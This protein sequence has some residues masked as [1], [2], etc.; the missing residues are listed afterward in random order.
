VRVRGLTGG[1]LLTIGFVLLLLAGN[2][3]AFVYWASFQDNKIGRANN[4]GTG[5]NGSF[6]STGAG[7]SA[8]A[9]NGSHIYWVNQTGDTIGRANLD[10]TGADNNFITGVNAPNAVAVSNSFL[11]WSSTSPDR[12]GRANLDGT[13]PNPNLIAG[14]ITPCGVAAD[15]GH[16]Y[17]TEDNGS[18]SHIG[19]SDL[20]G[21]SPSHTFVTI[22]GTSF[23]CGVAVNTASIFWT[24]T[25][26]F[27][28]GTNIGRA[29]VTTGTGADASIIGDA[30]TPFG[31]AVDSSHLYWANAATNTIGRSN[32]D[33][34]A[35][36]QGFVATGGN[37]VA[38][39]AVD[40]LMPSGGSP[41]PSNAFTIGA[42]TRNKKKGTA[43]LSANVPN[44]GEL[45]A[46]GSG[47][48]ASS[49][50]RAVT[51]KSVG[52]GQAQLLIKA[53]GKEKRKLNETGKVKLNV[54]VTYT[55]TGGDPSTQSVKVKLKKKL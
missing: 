48:R 5:V 40:S 53:T 35:V 21:N 42:I 26:L 22:P 17:W 43:T 28:G 29:N 13:S 3:Q 11:F 20:N 36:N 15:S 27:G 34:T 16:L 54:A 19:R 55:P 6:I 52:A 14:V 1:L 25:G 10:G 4:D 38:G 23:P 51:S 33:A 45:T 41:M 39:V 31:V 44:P 12:V 24:D 8:V 9:V 30:S 18:P 2:A 7:P 50:G 46:S 37:Q 47:V 32:A 49:A